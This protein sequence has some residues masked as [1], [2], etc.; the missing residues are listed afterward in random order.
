MLR[1][2]IKIKIM[3]ILEVVKKKEVIAAVFV[4]IIVLFNLI[5]LFYS[6]IFQFLFVSFSIFHINSCLIS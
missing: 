1:R 2:M 5:Q 3:I 6:F 4:F